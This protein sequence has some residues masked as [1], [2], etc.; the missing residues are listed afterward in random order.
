MAVWNFKS[1]NG[2]S[3]VIKQATAMNFTPLDSSRQRA[4][5]QIKIFAKFAKKYIFLI[6]E[7]FSLKRSCLTRGIQRCQIHCSKSLNNG[8]VAVWSFKILNGHSSVIKQP[9]AMNFTPLDSSR[10]RA[11]FQIKIF[12]K[13]AKKYFF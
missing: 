2:H 5:F 1:L 7:G 10:Q 6:F 4:S 12:A 9:T 13:F 3:C 8:V 11:S